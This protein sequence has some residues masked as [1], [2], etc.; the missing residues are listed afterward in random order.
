V[1]EKPQLT[2]SDARETAKPE[3]RRI[4]VG[5]GWKKLDAWK[6]ASL[7]NRGKPGGALVLDY[8]STTLVPPGWIFRVDSAGNLL[9]TV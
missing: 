5:G 2:R 8:G 4:W 1:L 3:Q 6:R 9:L 7:T